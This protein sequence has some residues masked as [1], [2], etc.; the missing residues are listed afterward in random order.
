MRIKKDLFFFH[1]RDFVLY[2]ARFEIVAQ[3]AVLENELLTG[4]IRVE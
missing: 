4:S 1:S 2:L 3:R